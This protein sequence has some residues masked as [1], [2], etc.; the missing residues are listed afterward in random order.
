MT[1]G[2]GYFRAS[3]LLPGTYRVEVQ[4]TGFQNWV[5]S[6]VQIDANQMR[7]VYPRLQIGEQ[8]THVEV[9]ATAEGIETGKSAVATNIAVATME[10]APMPSRNIYAAVA[11]IAPGVTGPGKVFAS[12]SSAGQDSFQAEPGL[13]INSAGQ[14]QQ[15]NDDQEDSSSVNG[16]SRDCIPT[17][18]R[19]PAP[20]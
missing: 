18:P 14:R 6:P 15:A 10:T 17:L 16:T 3:E 8:S 20:V 7:S 9:S 2:S 12:G 19:I 5:E 1:N 11:F 13:Q 4:L